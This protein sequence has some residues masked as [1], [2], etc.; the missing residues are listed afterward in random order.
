MARV[1]PAWQYFLAAVVGYV[2][3]TILGAQTIGWA[4]FVVMGGFGIAVA[5]GWGHRETQKDESPLPLLGV[6][7]CPACGAPVAEHGPTCDL[8]GRS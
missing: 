6:E 8:A 4:I 3:A 7:A 1:Y 5:T 2:L